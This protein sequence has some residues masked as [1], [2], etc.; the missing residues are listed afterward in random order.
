MCTNC[1]SLLR[2]GAIQLGADGGLVLPSSAVEGSFYFDP[3]LV[4]AA[5]SQ[6]VI[7]DVA[8]QKAWDL[9]IEGEDIF[10]DTPEQVCLSTSPNCC[11]G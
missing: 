10:I 3:A 2:Q 11:W 1:V 7:D 8:A 5:D 4:E 6:A 9:F